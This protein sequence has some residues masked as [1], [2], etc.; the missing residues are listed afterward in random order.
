MPRKAKMRPA[1]ARGHHRV[2]VMVRFRRWRQ[3]ALLGAMLAIVAVAP[4]AAG[5][6]RAEPTGYFLEFR[7]RAGYLFGHSYIA[8]GR[9]D[10]R[11]RPLETRLAGVYPLDGTAGLIVGT[12]VPVPASVR[13][14]AED[15]RQPPSN[16]YRLTLSAAQYARLRGVVET[17]ARSEREWDLLFRNCNDFAIAVARGMGLAAPPSWLPPPA[18]VEALRLLNGG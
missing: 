10:A 14:V 18:F 1:S 9:L 12:L 13:G 15:Y 11:G 3:G 5:D 17:L 4:A 6:R 8:Y 2:G 16:V 7:S